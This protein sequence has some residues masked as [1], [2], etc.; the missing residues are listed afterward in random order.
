M[1]SFKLPAYS[2]DE[3]ASTEDFYDNQVDRLRSQ[4]YI[5]PTNVSGPSGYTK[6][7]RI[8]L[9]EG[10]KV[11]SNTNKVVFT[12]ANPTPVEPIPGAIGRGDASLTSFRIILID[13]SGPP[14]NDTE[15]RYDAPPYPTQISIPFASI[16]RTELEQETGYD[17]VIICKDLR[18]VRVG[19][20]GGKPF[21]TQFMSVLSS[22]AFPQETKVLFA[23]ARYSKSLPP[24]ESGK[25]PTKTAP[26]TPANSQKSSEELHKS[27]AK[28]ISEA[29]VDGWLVFTPE[30]EFIRQG[31]L[32]QGSNWRLWQDNYTLVPTYPS[33]FIVP[34]ALN[35]NEIIEAAKFRS[36]CRLP[37]LTWKSKLTGACL[38]RSS[39]PMAGFANKKN[40][41]DKLLL[42]LFRMR[43]N[44]FD[45][46]ERVD[47]STFY[48][49]DCRSQLAANANAVMGKG[50][51]NFKNLVQT[52]VKLYCLRMISL[53]CLYICICFTMDYRFCFVALEIFIRCELLSICCIKY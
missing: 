36:R 48:I 11:L 16:A 33:A 41:C 7:D 47:P 24:T 1:V 28:P 17:I 10:E 43:G 4:S 12:M 39:Q 31:L 26:K 8:E 15:F 40:L 34:A 27:L 9:I 50:V 35:D 3:G 18:V 38:C 23:F 44:A 52:T 51:E 29:G 13:N 53:I 21:A 42:N 20:T 22:Y 2:S 6:I 45:E 46:R 30:K 14:A 37:A 19:F 32:Y 49:I 25:L 5:V